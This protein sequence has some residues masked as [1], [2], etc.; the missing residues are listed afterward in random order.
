MRVLV[1][2]DDII[3]LKLLVRTI[4]DWGDSVETVNNGTDA[5]KILNTQN[6]PQLVVLDWMMP[7]MD[8][9]EICKKLRKQSGENYTYIILLTT[10]SEKN[11]ITKGLE[12]GADDYLTKP[13]YPSELKARLNAGK[14][15]ITLQNKLDASRKEFMLLATKDPLTNLWNRRAIR[16]ILE[17]DL[18]R[19]KRYKNY[20]CVLMADLDN[21]KK[22]NDSYGHSVGDQVLIESSNIMI[23]TVRE[24]DSVARYGG[25]EFLIILPMSDLKQGLIVGERI[26]LSLYSKPIT[27]SKIELQLSL[28]IGVAEY[29]GQSKI[30]KDV[31][32][33]AADAA[34]YRAKQSG[35]NRV[36]PATSEDL[37][38]I[39]NIRVDANF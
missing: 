32:I 31:L 30:D 24:C 7:G 33:N 36:E 17:K 37:K 25:E 5:W 15:I 3:S 4:S 29:D 13:F 2:E 38:E 39:S 6:P 22:I 23:K 35:R 8:G 18:L 20:L 19:S 21:F 16:D 10:K 12:A 26:R 28:S 34:M 9:I 27:T 11:D 1:A 14:R